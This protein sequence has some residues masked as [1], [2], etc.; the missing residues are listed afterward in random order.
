VSTSTSPVGW[1]IVQTNTGK[2]SP[3]TR[4]SAARSARI[5]HRRYHR[6][7][8][9]RNEHADGP[10]SAHHPFLTRHAC[11]RTQ[12][13]SL[14]SPGRSCVTIGGRSAPRQLEGACD[15][16]ASLAPR[17][18]ADD[19]QVLSG[20][21]RSAGPPERLQRGAACAPVLAASVRGRAYLW[22]CESAWNFTEEAGRRVARCRGSHLYQ[23]LLPGKVSVGE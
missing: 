16:S 23:A 11:D 8:F 21:D 19:P 22:P 5:T 3:S 20:R 4:S 10:P 1:S 13:G 18:R 15:R 12:C 7:K 14:G 6:R 17:S 2:R 9:I